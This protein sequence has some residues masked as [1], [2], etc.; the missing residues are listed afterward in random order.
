M[1]V[2][3]QGNTVRHF[4]FVFTDGINPIFPGSDSAFRTGSALG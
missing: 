2:K 1:F 3:E 4:H